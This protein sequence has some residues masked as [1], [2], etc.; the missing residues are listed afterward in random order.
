[1]NLFTLFFEILF[2]EKEVPKLPTSIDDFSDLPKDYKLTLT[3]QR[4]LALKFS[5]LLLNG[6]E[7]ELLRPR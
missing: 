3:K 7:M 5:L 4:L 2:Q 6:G 1:M